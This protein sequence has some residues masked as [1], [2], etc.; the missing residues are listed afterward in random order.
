MS[1]IPVRRVGVMKFSMNLR[2]SFLV[3]APQHMV[4]GGTKSPRD[5]VDVL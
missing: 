2:T 4:R 5:I 3:G 1:L